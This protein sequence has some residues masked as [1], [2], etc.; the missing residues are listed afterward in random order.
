MKKHS[1]ELLA[2]IVLCS[3]AAMAQKIE[4]PK[5]EPTP[6]TPEQAQRIKEG[7]ALHDRRDFDAAITLYQAVLKEN[8]NNVLALYEM[9]Y[10]YFEKKDYQKSLEAG[11]KASQYKSDLLPQIYVQIGSAQD[12]MGEPKK[13]IETYKAAQKLFPTNYLI[14]FNLAITYNKL[15]AVEDA[16]T[17]AKRAAELNPNH[18]SS[19]M[20]LA[21]L[22]DRGSYKTPSLLAV[23]RFLILEPKSQRSPGALRLFLKITQGGVATGENGNINIFMD[24]SP[25]KDEGDF[26]AIDL[27][28]SIARAAESVEKNKDK[29]EMQKMVGSFETLLAIL[30]ESKPDRSKFTWRHYYPYFV[31]LQKQGHVEAFIYYINQASG[32]PEIQDW[33]ANHTDKVQAFLTWSKNYAWPKVE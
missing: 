25:K 8:P 30:S 27:S 29:T 11:Y 26:G 16:R 31:G 19:Q 14:P 7:I 3:C 12:E 6:S 15:S 18:A 20:V 1:L 28:I 32:S 5:L 13:A 4:A 9:A 21:I 33:L 2:V 17:A 23:S 22:F 24:P 10:S